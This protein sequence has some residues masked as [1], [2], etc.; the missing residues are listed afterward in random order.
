MATRK[1]PRTREWNIPDLI[2]SCGDV[3]ASNG[4]TNSRNEEGCRIPGILPNVGKSGE[5]V[6]DERVP[7]F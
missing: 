7:I 5:R 2:R 6:G 4:R 3:G 1:G